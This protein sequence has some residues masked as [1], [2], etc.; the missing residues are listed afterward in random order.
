[1]IINLPND[2]VSSWIN[3][4]F[5]RYYW[6][7][8]YDFEKKISD[9]IDKKRNQFKDETSKTFN[10][11]LLFKLIVIKTKKQIFKNN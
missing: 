1:M 9:E 8:V 6:I 7:S 5:K 2:F 11:Q 10:N 4:I 3:S